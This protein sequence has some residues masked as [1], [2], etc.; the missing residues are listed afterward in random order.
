MAGLAIRGSDSAI[1]AGK[2][3][4]IAVMN[5]PVNQAL[6]PCLEQLFAGSGI[7]GVA[8]QAYIAFGR[9]HTVIEDY[10]ALLAA[11]VQ[12]RR[13]IAGAHRGSQAKQQTATVK[14]APIP[15]RNRDMAGLIKPG[16]CDLWREHSLLPP[17]PWQLPVRRAWFP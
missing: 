14:Y 2:A 3:A 17:S 13:R 4:F 10:P 16:R 9:M 5:G 1:V 12:H 11:T 6:F 7:A 15:V 8:I